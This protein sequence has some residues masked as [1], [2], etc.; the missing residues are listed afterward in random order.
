[1]LDNDPS[2]RGHLYR[3]SKKNAM[4]IQQAIVHHKRGKEFNFYIER[5]SSYLAF[6]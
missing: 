3:V 6:Q 5:K 2:V 1:M 4:E